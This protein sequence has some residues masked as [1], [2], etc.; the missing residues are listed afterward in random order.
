MPED[1]DVYHY[2]SEKARLE[3][4]IED[5]QLKIDDLDEQNQRLIIDY[6]KA[7]K[8]KGFDYQ[9][10]YQLTKKFVKGTRYFKDETLL[11]L[12]EMEGLI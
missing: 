1:I 3:K 4:E 2:I 9:A 12:I 6:V 5:K 10:T 11:P 8:R 7:L